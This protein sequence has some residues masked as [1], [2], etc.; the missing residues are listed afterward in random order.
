MIMP[1][2][3]GRETFARLKELNPKIKAIL[4]TGYSRDGKAQEILDEGMMGYIQ[5]PYQVDALLSKVRS[6]LDAET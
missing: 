5:K 4:S 3:G 2:M 6:T 1:Q